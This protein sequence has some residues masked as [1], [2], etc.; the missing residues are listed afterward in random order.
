MEAK[1]RQYTEWW[2]DDEKYPKAFDL[3]HGAGDNYYGYHK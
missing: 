3:K 1:D 2:D